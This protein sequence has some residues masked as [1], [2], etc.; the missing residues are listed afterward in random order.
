MMFLTLDCGRRVSVDA[1]DYSRTYSGLLMGLPNA[2]INDRIIERALVGRESSWGKRPTHLIQPVIERKDPEHPRLAP[3]LLRAWL[4]CNEPVNPNFMGSE[5]V[6]V[7]FSEECHLDSIDNIV[8]RAVC[9]LPWEQ[10]AG[11]FDW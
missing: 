6:V 3:V 5:L 8:S 9:G 7:W 4:T 1:I 2:E 11:D 10:L